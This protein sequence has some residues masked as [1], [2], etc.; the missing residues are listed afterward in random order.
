MVIGQEKISTVKITLKRFSIY[1]LALLL[2][3]GIIAGTASALWFSE[4][5]SSQGNITVTL[6]PNS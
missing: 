5:T 6:S 1:V 2:L 3:N 4:T